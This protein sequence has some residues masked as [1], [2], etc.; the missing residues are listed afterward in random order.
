MDSVTAS[1]ALRSTTDSLL[2]AAEWALDTPLHA[3]RRNH[4]LTSVMM[5]QRLSPP[6]AN[7]RPAP[8]SIHP[9]ASS[10]RRLAS[11]LNEAPLAVNAVCC[12]ICR[13]H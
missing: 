6:P 8:L 4:Q 13:R 11:A 3:R 9:E 2:S 7:L 5:L 10:H 12:G 1:F